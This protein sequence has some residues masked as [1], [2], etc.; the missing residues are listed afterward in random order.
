MRHNHRKKVCRVEEVEEVEERVDEDAFYF[1]LGCSFESCLAFAD[2]G[3]V[4]ISWMMLGGL[5]G[6]SRCRISEHHFAS[7][8]R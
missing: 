5:F 7:Q 8:R 6:L 4:H 3:V 2:V 1:E